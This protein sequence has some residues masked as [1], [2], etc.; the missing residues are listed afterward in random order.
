M[1]IDIIPC[2]SD[3]Y[4]YLINDKTS[5]LVGIVDPSDFDEVNKIIKRKYGKLDYILNT[6][7]HSDHVAGN[8]ELKKNY[9]SKI[10]GSKAD[11]NRIPGIDILLDE[12]EIFKFGKVNF[13]IITVPGHTKGHIAFYSED[14]KT[15]FTGDTLFSLGCG[16]VFEGTIKE[17]FLS[18]NKIKSLPGDTK[19]YCGHEYTKQNLDFCLKFDENNQFL[20]KKLDWVKERNDNK[21]PTIPTTLE[22]E[23]KTNI[24]LR[25]DNSSIKNIL[26]MNNSSDEQIFEKLRSLKDQF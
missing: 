3:N 14:E 13:K 18:I 4:S 8:I 12:G 11:G 15:I 20:I 23:V 22:E 25:C 10:V 17:M 16:R 2:L 19:I 24:F 7:H 21:M 26:N 5:N 1:I 6:H 9:K